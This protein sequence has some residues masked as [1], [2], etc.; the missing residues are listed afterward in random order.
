MQEAK[1]REISQISLHA[2]AEGKPL[3]EQFGFK[4]KGTEMVWGTYV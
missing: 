2:T 1:Q 4:Q 3:Y